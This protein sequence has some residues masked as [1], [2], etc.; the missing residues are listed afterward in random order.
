MPVSYK[1]ASSFFFSTS[2]PNFN[3]SFHCFDSDNV[4]KQK[5][6]Q[7]GIFEKTLRVYQRLC[8]SYI[9]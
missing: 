2:L 4:K 9:W 3:R 5:L 1:S 7:S 6:V 8:Y